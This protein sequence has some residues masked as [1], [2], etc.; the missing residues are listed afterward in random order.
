[1]ILKPFT[2]GQVLSRTKLNELVKW[3]NLLLG[4]TIKRGGADKVF[5]SESNIIYQLNKNA[6]AAGGSGMNYRGEWDEI[7]YV[8]GDVV[9]VSPDNAIASTATPAG[10][11]IPGVYVC[12]QDT[13]E[14]N[15]PLHP[16]QTGG[17]NAYWDWLSTYPS[18]ITICVA[19]EQLT[20]LIDAQEKI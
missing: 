7:A 18:E 17:E 5:V 4:A 16:L 3:L 10:D 15:P 19:G 1:M 6:S 9:R 8:A 14:T 2:K 20:Y 12:M 13:D 11:T